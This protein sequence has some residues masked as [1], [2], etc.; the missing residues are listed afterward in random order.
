MSYRYAIK[1]QLEKRLPAA[2]TQTGFSQSCLMLGRRRRGRHYEF[3]ET[4]REPCYAPL[5][6]T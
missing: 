4:G 6:D 3:V 2:N 1:A 5:A